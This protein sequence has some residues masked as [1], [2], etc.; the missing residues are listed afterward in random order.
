MEM[1]R[2]VVMMIIMLMMFIL[3]SSYIVAIID[4]F[5]RFDVHFTFSV[6]SVLKAATATIIITQMTLFLFLLI[7][8]TK[9]RHSC[10][11]VVFYFF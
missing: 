2:I 4:I 5:L 1:I 6:K 3:I 7:M 10:Y 8:M 9:I 11:F